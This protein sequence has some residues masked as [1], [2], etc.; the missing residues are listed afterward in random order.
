MNNI[1][2]ENLKKLNNIELERLDFYGRTSFNTRQI[3]KTGLTKA[4][5]IGSF[6]AILLYIYFKIIGLS[7]ALFLSFMVFCFLFRIKPNMHLEYMMTSDDIR[8]YILHIEGDNGFIQQ[9]ETKIT[10]FNEAEKVAL[11]YSKNKQFDE[12]YIPDYF[13][14][15]KK[16]RLIEK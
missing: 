3:L 16:L 7:L 14:I 8:E 9:F 11:N 4:F 12:I 2:T 15:I 13:E 5:V 1:D 6:I 10:D